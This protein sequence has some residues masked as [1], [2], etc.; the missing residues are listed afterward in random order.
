MKIINEIIGNTKNK[1]KD[2]PENVIIN[3]TTV[4]EKQEITGNLNNYFT[5]IGPNLASKVP[6]EQGGFE[7]Y[8]MNDAPLTDEELRDTSFLLED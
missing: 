1:R 4:V 8:L 5:N 2:L 7:K 3:N 6:N